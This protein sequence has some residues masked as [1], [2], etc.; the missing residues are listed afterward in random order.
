MLCSLSLSISFWLL[1]PDSETKILEGYRSMVDGKIG[2]TLL[3][4]DFDFDLNELERIQ[5]NNTIN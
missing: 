4:D 3:E 1:I 5:S 2:Q